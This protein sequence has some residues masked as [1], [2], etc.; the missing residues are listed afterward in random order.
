L[1]ATR[2]GFVGYQGILN[3]HYLDADNLVAA[4]GEVIGDAGDGTIFF[5][6]DR[7]I[8]HTNMKAR[9][10]YLGL[11]W[12][13]ISNHA[14]EKEIG[15]IQQKREWRGFFDLM[16]APS[17]E[18]DPMYVRN[19]TDGSVNRYL[20]DHGNG[21][22]FERRSLGFRAGGEYMRYLNSQSAINVN[23]E[24][25]IRPGIANI[26]NSDA[27]LGGSLYFQWR[28]SYQFGFNIFE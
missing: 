4:S 6:E 11:E 17:I 20:V 7:N 15:I 3:N 23:F 24:S 28:I 22:G 27:L 13:M 14:K 10:L 9:I 16:Y 19:F 1:L 18:I 2:L 12:R 5:P 26:T 25:G 8:Y 21:G